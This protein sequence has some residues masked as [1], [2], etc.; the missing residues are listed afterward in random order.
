MTGLRRESPAV[1]QGVRA[2]ARV[3]PSMPPVTRAGVMFKDSRDKSMR[4][5]GKS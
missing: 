2:L 3:T 5:T 4:G 1:E